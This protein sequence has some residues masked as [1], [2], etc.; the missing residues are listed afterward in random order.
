MVIGEENAGR[1]IRPATP[2]PDQASTVPRPR[3]PDRHDPRDGAPATRAPLDAAEGEI[4]RVDTAQADTAQADTAQ[5]DTAQVDTEADSAPG[6]ASSGADQRPRAPR[7]PVR[8]AHG[9]A[10]WARRPS[11]Q[12]ALPGLLLFA[13][14]ATA[15]AAGALVVP[16]TTEKAASPRSSVPTLVPASAAPPSTTAPGN[17]TPTATAT[18]NTGAH[19]N[20]LASGRPSDILADWASTLSTK[21]DIPAVALQAYGYAELVLART[22]PEC[23]LTWTTLA[24]IGYVESRHGQAFGATLGP[25]GVPTPAIIGPP[26]NGRGGTRLIRD[27]DRGELDG[28]RIYDR[29]V[30]PMQ[31]LPTTWREVGVDADNDGRK[32]PNN[33][34]D[35]ALAAGYYLCRGDRDLTVAEDWWNAVL[36]YNDVISYARE[37]FDVA[38]DYGRRSRA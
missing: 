13:L 8:L 20:S 14:I 23:R 27:T 21:L 4:V 24:A 35:A 2:P 12:L 22:K 30:G 28:D 16:V 25:D 33:I 36:S 38:N 26:L 15:G 29:A 6:A 9:L 18:A 10:S 1:P 19:Q 11:G 34:H 17:L 5:T 32:D 7:W 37:V 3:S 31:F